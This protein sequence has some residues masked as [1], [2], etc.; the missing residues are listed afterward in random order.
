M[1]QYQNFGKP[2]DQIICQD[3][4]LPGNATPVILTNVCTIDAA[5]SGKLWVRVFASD[6]T[7]EIAD[8]DCLFFV[9]VV[10]TTATEV[11]TLAG[12]GHI[13]PAIYINGATAI[14][15]NGCKM[16]TVSWASGLLICEFALPKDQ[17]LAEHKY[18]AIYACIASSGT[19]SAP[20]SQAADNIEA[21]LFVE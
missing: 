9:P 2:Y 17:I 6:T 5:K 8:P 4:A 12:G 1:A 16:S 14:T 15:A 7:V 10:G 11:A 3:Y 20:A 13:L 19:A 18:L 21:Y